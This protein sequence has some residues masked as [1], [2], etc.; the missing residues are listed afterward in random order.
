MS[1][2]REVFTRIHPF[3]SDLLLHL[4]IWDTA[5]LSLTCRDVYNHIRQHPIA[6]SKFDLRDPAAVRALHML[7]ENDRHHQQSQ[8]HSL[9]DFLT[10]VYH[11]CYST[12][13]L[14]RVF[15]PALAFQTLVLEHH[16]KVR[17]MLLDGIH[18]RKWMLSEVLRITAPTLEVLSLVFTSGCRFDEFV[19]MFNKELELKKLRELKVGDPTESS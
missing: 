2:F 1:N 14:R 11:A 9:C 10:R 16:V 3:A 13:R 17:V 4:D 19:D 12:D 8:R 6:F 18:V 7:V 15:I 5:A